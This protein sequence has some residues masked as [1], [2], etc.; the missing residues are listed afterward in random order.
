[1]KKLRRTIL[2]SKSE[3]NVFLFSMFFGGLWWNNTNISYTTD[4]TTYLY[5]S[6]YLIGQRSFGSYAY[7]RTLGYPIVMLLAGVPSMGTFKGLFILQFFLGVYIPILFRKTLSSFQCPKTINNMLTICLILTGLPYFYTKAVMNEQVYI[8]MMFLSIYLFL[9]YVLH[10]TEKYQV[11]LFLSAAMLF[12]LRPSGAIFLYFFT[13]YFVFVMKL[14]KKKWL[15]YFL[16]FMFCMSVW[17]VWV[18]KNITPQLHGGGM[19]GRFSQ[20]LI[21]H[22]L[23]DASKKQDIISQSEQ[24]NN[25]FHELK[26]ILE[27]SV[28]VEKSHQLLSGMNVDNFIAM[29]DIISKNYNGNVNL[30]YRQSAYD[31]FL[32]HPGAV[33]SYLSTYIFGG[34]ISF[35]GQQL[36]YHAYAKSNILEEN[37]PD[38]VINRYIEL[39]ILDFLTKHP[40]LIEKR[41]PRELFYR[42]AGKPDELIKALKANPNK[43]YFWFIWNIIDS[44]LSPVESSRLFA[45]IAVSQ[46]VDNPFSYALILYNDLLKTIFSGGSDYNR[47]YERVELINLSL[48]TWVEPS[49]YENEKY[50]NIVLELEGKAQTSQNP[51]WPIVWT[52]YKISIHL[53]LL[54][55][56]ILMAIDD[57]RGEFFAL[58]SIWGGMILTIVL[59]AE[60][61][62]RYFIHVWPVSIILSSVVMARVWQYFYK[63]DSHSHLKP[64]MGNN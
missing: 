12:L 8:F 7:L 60:P 10:K 17:K 15:V 2:E 37:N 34:N 57:R 33:W 20:S 13:F 14:H 22:S 16:I 61:I 58:F 48:G 44:Q 64:C 56:F 19:T 54:F 36:F 28:G 26:K 59:F 46:M 43:D 24:K 63:N 25:Y 21:Y 4:S 41:E 18:V 6:E 1:M 38:Q 40:E 39:N 11:Y 42:F 50:H 62:S 27:L 53:L 45:E 30:L 9:K 47:G 23:V 5:F 35:M 55:G 51:L 31:Y 49:F 3:I 32:K 52:L 29:K